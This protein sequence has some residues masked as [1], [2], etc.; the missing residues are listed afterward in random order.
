MSKYTIDE[1]IN[2]VTIVKEVCREQVCCDACPF[3]TDGDCVINE[4]TPEDW[5]IERP[6]CSIFR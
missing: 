1:M 2:A 4:E 5:E 6:E 3:C